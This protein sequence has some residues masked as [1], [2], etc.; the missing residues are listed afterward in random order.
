MGYTKFWITSGAGVPLVKGV[1]PH[2][3][4]PATVGSVVISTGTATAS[5]GTSSRAR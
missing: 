2:L 5:T 3:V 1:D 4:S